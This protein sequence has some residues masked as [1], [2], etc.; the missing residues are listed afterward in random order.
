[1]GAIYRALIPPSVY[2]LII[3]EIASPSRAPQPQSKRSFKG[4]VLKLGLRVSSQ[5]CELL[6]A[7][8]VLVR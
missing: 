5:N 1:M 6:T 2:Q 3:D 8:P 7:Q 4:S